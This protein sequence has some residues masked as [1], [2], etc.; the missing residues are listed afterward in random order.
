MEFGIIITLRDYFSSGV[1]RLGKLL[2][3]LFL[4]TDSF[5]TGGSKRQFS[6]LGRSLDRH[7]LRL[8]IGCIPEKAHSLDWVRSSIP[9]WAATC[10]ACSRLRSRLLLAQHLR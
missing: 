6:A 4:M 3:G 10:M 5:E 7:L 1:V 9:A 8:H 2:P